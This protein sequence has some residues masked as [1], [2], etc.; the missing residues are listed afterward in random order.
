MSF[1]TSKMELH[2]WVNTILLLMVSFL[3][4]QTYMRIDGGLKDATSNISK[5]ETRITVLEDHDRKRKQTGF[6]FREA[7]LP[8]QLKIKSEDDK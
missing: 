1:P 5:H 6:N 8:N 4:G 2:Q 7:V 3:L